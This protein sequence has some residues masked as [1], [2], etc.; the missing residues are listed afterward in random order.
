MW[1]EFDE[2]DGGEND[3]RREGESPSPYSFRISELIVFLFN[4][5]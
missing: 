1:K 4:I 5:L 2:D 3:G